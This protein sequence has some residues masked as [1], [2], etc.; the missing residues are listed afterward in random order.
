MPIHLGSI[1][2]R[3][4]LGAVA[5]GAAALVV[6][7]A[8]AAETAGETDFLA[9]LSDTHVPS[10]SSITNIDTNMTENLQTVVKELLALEV[11]PVGVVI[12]GDCA[13]LKGLTD[14]YKNLATVLA[15]L[16]NADLP[17][18]LSMGN[19]DHRTR[20]YEQ[21]K[22]QQPEKPIV[23]GKHV[24]VLE[25]PRANWFLLDSLFETDVVTGELG[26]T[27]L[28]W[29]AAALDAHTDKPAIVMAHHHLQWE[30][31]DPISG[32]RETSELF[33]MLTERKH[34]K[35][36]L[37]G[38]THRWDVKERDGIHLVNL[39]PTAYVFE[40]GRP[41]GWV[42]AKVKDGGMTLELHALDK[43]HSQNGQRVELAWR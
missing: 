15:P 37:F 13:Y 27:Q 30:P 22:E 24:S 17:V 38:H 12:N 16:R 32:L 28:K 18:H 39:P 29:L 41:N 34:V 7:D 3:Q 5:A 20:M 36:Y 10:D 26:Q 4:F 25:M 42:A 1:S 21:L 40:K 33:Q 14:D 23:E 6:R 9:L 43:Q 19:H 35:A 11:K 31:T 8:Y 2:R